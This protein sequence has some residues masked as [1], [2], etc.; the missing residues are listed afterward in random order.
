MKNLAKDSKQSGHSHHDRSS[1]YK[2]NSLSLTGAVAMGTGVMIGAGIFALTGQ[3]AQQAGSLFPWAFLA[4]ALIASLSAHAYVR[5]SQAH[6]SAG[7][8]A[9]YLMKAYGKGTVTAGCALLMFFSMVINESLVARTFG[10]YTLQLF[11]GGH[12]DWWVPALG[13]GL[14]IFAFGI[15]LIG[16]RY[17]SGISLVTA[18]V[19]IVGITVFAGAGLWLSGFSFESSTASSGSAV[20]Q[21]SFLAAVAITLLAYKG[22]TT[23]TNSGSELKQPKKNVARAIIISLAICGVV[24]LAVALAVAGNLSLDEIIK[25]RDYALAEAARP[26]FGE[27]GL[28]FTVALAIV[29]T[30]SGVIASVFAV[31]RMLAMLT[32]MSLVPHRHFKMPGTIQDHTLVYTIVLAI[33]LT[34]FFDLGRIASLGAIFYLVMDIAVQWGVFRHLRK[35]I[36]A[37][38][39][40]LLS[41]LALDALI[42]TALLL[43]KGR[44]DPFILVVAGIG[45]LAIF[46]GERFFL[47]HISDQEDASS[48]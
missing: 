28:W 16:N 14:L 39:G 40:I 46:G 31:S 26:A 2:K 23:I 33:L 34:I 7:G 35:E 8:I 29:A 4:A 43:S 20:E 22:F 5:M 6:P 12:P 25:S 36:N 13:V 19:K 44:S 41:A 47:R 48:K 30:V 18:I 1:Q 45:V 37:H 10:S 24:Y 9:M 21:G 32:E 17:I 38:A 11:D 42:L 3:V 27:Y 15:N